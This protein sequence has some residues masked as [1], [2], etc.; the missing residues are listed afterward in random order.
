MEKY[1]DILEELILKLSKIT[2]IP[3]EKIRCSLENLIVSIGNDSKEKKQEIIEFP[4][5][6]LLADYMSGKYGERNLTGI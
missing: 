5:K 4:V 1:N 6:D 2:L 3:R